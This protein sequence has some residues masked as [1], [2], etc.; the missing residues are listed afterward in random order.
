MF[1][2]L[3]ITHLLSCVARITKGGDVLRQDNT[4]NS[5]SSM[6]SRRIMT[7][8][9]ICEYPKDAFQ[10]L[11]SRQCPATHPFCVID[12]PF[13]IL[14]N[15]KY[16]CATAPRRTDLVVHLMNSSQLLAQINSDGELYGG[17]SNCMLTAFYSPDCAFSIRMVSYLYQLPRMYPRLR[18]VATDARDHSKLNSRYGIIGTP[19][20]LLW[21]DG[22]V[23]SRMDEAPFSL[24]AF[25]NYIEKWT[26][27]ELE[28]IPAMENDGGLIENIQFHKSSFDWY[29][30]VSWCSFVLSTAYFFM[31]SKYGLAF[32]G[33]LRTNYIQVNEVQ[34]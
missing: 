15:Q 28:Y 27:L 5:E 12:V 8:N 1:N 33:T 20:I 26:D 17:H 24:N 29:L 4:T 21:V 19:T 9:M 13:D 2:V 22:S 14:L 32:L 31:N 16:R 25:R 10:V 34:R 11:I 23:V 30:C 6:S 18:I 3:L 7:T